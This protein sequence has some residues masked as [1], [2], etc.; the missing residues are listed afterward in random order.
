MSSRGWL[1]L[2]VVGLIVGAL[3]GEKVAASRPRLGSRPAPSRDGSIDVPNVAE[4][5]AIDGEFEDRAWVDAFRTGSFRRDGAPARPYSDAR[6]AW[7]EGT[8]FMTLYAADEDIHGAKAKHDEPLWTADSF[9]VSVETGGVTHRIDVS[10][11]GVVTDGVWSND[12]F[13]PS[14]ESRAVVAVD[15]DG[16]IDDT[17]DEDE[18]WVVELA[19][20]LSSLGL[21]GRPGERLGVS[22]ERC[23][24]IG[25]PGLGRRR[26]CARWPEIG[27]SELVLAPGV[28]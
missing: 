15:R 16:T 24:S 20:P 7:R 13:D 5:P 23:D 4:A 9:S 6:F 22:I 18:E 21:E 10:A 25:Q 17:S 27:E 26:A 8:L 12:R 14:W 28:R 11:G 19:L 3:A 2:V 1:G